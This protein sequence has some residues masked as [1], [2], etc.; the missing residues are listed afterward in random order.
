MSQLDIPDHI[1]NWLADFFREHSHQTHYSGSISQIKSISASII[2]GSAIGPTSYVVNA[3]DLHTICDGNEI[4]KYA[5]DTYLIVPAVNV[6]TRSA[7]LQHITDWANTNNLSLNLSKSNEI[8]FVDKR[9]K[10][11]FH[12]PNTLDGL[13]RVQNIKILG[14]T[15]TNGLS[16]TPHVQ[17]LVTSNAQV[18]YALKTSTC[19]RP[20]RQGNTSSL[21]FS[22][23]SAVIIRLA[24]MVGLCFSPRPAKSLWILTS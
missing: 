1:F 18:W 15:F 14:V 20:I 5:D 24:C 22:N 16:V 3:S 7:E 8:V 10:H 6:N 11:K 23:L 4:C 13:K 2:Q 21:P 17:H 19:T 12:V 9:R